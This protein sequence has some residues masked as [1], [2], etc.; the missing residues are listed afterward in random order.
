MLT[1]Q[2]SIVLLLIVLNGFFAMAEIALVS[3]RPAR[4]Q[5]LAAQGSRGAQAAL[6]L[7]IDGRRIARVDRDHIHRHY[8]YY[9]SLLVHFNH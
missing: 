5:P 2:L 7:G 1:L 9:T 4:L 3:A 8:Y 6:E